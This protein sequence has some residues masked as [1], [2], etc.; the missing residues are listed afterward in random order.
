MDLHEFLLTPQGDAYII[1]DSPVH[2]PGISK[3]TVDSVVQEIDI[4]TGLVV[5][6]WDALDHIPLS[7]SYF[8]PKSSGRI[9][10]PYHANSIAVENDGNLLISMRNTSA[11]YDVDRQTG[12]VLWTLGGKHSSFKMGPGT[13]TWGQHDVIVQP[14]GTLTLFDDGAGPP[15]VQPYSRAIHESIDETDMTAT[16]VRAYSHSPPLSADFEG[17]VQLLADGNAFVGWGQQPYFSEYNAAGRQIFDADFTVPSSSYRAY[18]FQWSGQPLT[19]PALGLA[20]NPGGGADLYAS[21]NGATD[22][23]AWR[24]LGGAAPDALAPVGGAAKRGFETDVQIHSALPY[25]AVQALGSAGQVLSTS[26]VRAMPPHVAIYGP[27]AFVPSNEGVV[28]LPVGCFTGQPCHIQTNVWAGRTL[29]A[30][31]GSEYLAQ[32]SG[33]FVYF[34][35]SSAG[36]RTLAGAHG[37]DL[38][39]RVRAQDSSGKSATTGIELVPFSTAGGGPRRSVVNSNTLRVIGS[40]DYVSN[41]WVG[42]ILSGCLGM[43][44]C[45]A[46]ITLSVGR[47]VIAHTGSE[48]L[49]ADE[50]GYL[51]FTLT[52][53]GHSMLARARGN[54][55][56]AHL[57]LRAGNTTADANIALIGFH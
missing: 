10:D 56:G 12:Q 39:V 23:S 48:F 36:R 53:A 11:V 44:A 35:L 50:L 4:K 26:P 29:I 40:V 24:V 25:F 46:R 52:R 1:A 32:N 8:T 42:G 41:D 7:D 30:H 47:T 34:R 5:F 14:N 17:S 13:I 45:H 51:S 15:Q 31:T 57:V 33:G 21:W 19:P 2:L 18:R 20:A 6:Q 3:P 37:R 16:L 49:G 43:A 9:F 54:Q 55:L 27:N 28:G 22:V 38:A